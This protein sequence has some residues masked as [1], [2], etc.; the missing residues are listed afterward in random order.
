MACSKCKKK[1]MREQM[2]KEIL[3]TEKWVITVVILVVGA[4]TYGLFSL[5]KNFI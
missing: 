3:K 2:E 1:E 5:I 4:A